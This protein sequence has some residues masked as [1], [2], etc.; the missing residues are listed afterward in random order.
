[1]SPEDMDKMRAMVKPV[2]DKYAQEVGEA[3]IQSM[4]AELDKI[5]QQKQ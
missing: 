1:M 4:Y 5:R 3:S 2:V